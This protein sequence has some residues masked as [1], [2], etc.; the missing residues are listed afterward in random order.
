[1]D[2]ERVSSRHEGDLD[3]TLQAYSQLTAVVVRIVIPGFVATRSDAQHTAWMLL[4]LL[5]R[6]DGIVSKII[7]DCPDGIPVQERIIPFGN[8]SSLRDRLIEAARIIDIVEVSGE[9]MPNLVGHTLVI[10]DRPSG[11]L[12]EVLVWGSA[13]WGGVAI[14]GSPPPIGWLSATDSSL[15][16]GPYMAAVFAAAHVFL[17][18]RLPPGA[19]RE[20]GCYGWDCWR[21]RTR[22]QPSSG[23]AL[24]LEVRTDGVALAGAGAVGSAWMHAVWAVQGVVGEIQIADSDPLGVTVTNLNRGVLFARADLGTPKALVAARSA[25]GGVTWRTHHGRFEDLGVRPSVLV[26]AVDTNTSRASLQARYPER[27]M[28]GSTRDL[29][30]EVLLCG[31]P[32]EGACLRCYNAPK[33]KPSDEEL[34]RLALDATEGVVDPA[35][36]ALSLGIAEATIR[37]FLEGGDCSEMGERALRQLSDQYDAPMPPFSVGFVSVAAGT[38]LAVETVRILLDRT[39]VYPLRNPRINA[40]SVTVQFQRPAA[41][42][43]G[44]SILA[45]DPTCPACDAGPRLDVWLERYARF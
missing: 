6:A 35:G 25:Q 20:T 44:W 40:N 8:A 5:A 38:L 37:E 39:A 4:N 13:W 42:V 31:P 19:Y 14:G 10:G 7:L 27:L 21:Q 3:G 2:I 32:G 1:M 28:S 16:F 9:K 34:R 17:D 29:R 15:P 18:V 33:P 30:A 23:P 24:D 26:S 36:L 22:A 45:R 41:A 12:N 43:N 11:V